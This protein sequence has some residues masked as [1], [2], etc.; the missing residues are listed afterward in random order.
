[1]RNSLFFK[2]ASVVI[3]AMLTVYIAY[4]LISG[5]SDPIKTVRAVAVS[6]DDAITVEGVFL[7]DE[8]PVSSSSNGLMKYE[9][10]NG[11]KVAKGAR[12]ALYYQNEKA[13]EVSGE[14]LDLDYRIKTLQTARDSASSGADM[15]KINLSISS[16]ITDIAEVVQGTSVSRIYDMV[17]ELKSAMLK[18][19]LAY[20]GTLEIDDIISQLSA[21]RANLASQL[22]KSVSGEYAAVPG[23]FC[24][25]TDGYENKLSLKDAETMTSSEVS[26]IIKECG[27]S[28]GE[29]G[30]SDIG[31]LIR[32]YTWYFVSAMDQEK[33]EMLSLNKRYNV[34]FPNDMDRNIYVTVSRIKTEKDG[35]VT[36]VFK[37]TNMATELFPK[38]TTEMKIVFTTYSGI[39]VPKEAIRLKDGEMGV[40]CVDGSKARFKNV[41]VVYETETYYIAKADGTKTDKLFIYDDIIIAGKGIEDKKVIK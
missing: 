28:S 34:S 17:D 19:E 11:E 26:Q 24:Y 3:V 37:G 31:K 20:E 38:R 23:Y 15:G 14:I 7:R 2:I 27:D 9:V 4:Q 39:K 33:A 41:E 30:S 29:T 25:E 18:R 5:L 12:I 35:N 40:Y 21:E 16:Q 22:G 36:V 1:M 8:M 32:G 13:A 10:Y 6:V